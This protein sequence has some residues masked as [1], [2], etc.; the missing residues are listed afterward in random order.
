MAGGVPLVLILL[1]IIVVL[2]L[3]RRRRNRRRAALPVSQFAGGWEQVLDGAV[4]LG[5]GVP[6]KLTRSESAA[7]IDGHFGC[8]ATLLA[9]TA[10]RQV[11]G[12]GDPD[13]VDAERFW[14]EVDSALSG[15]RGTVS[16]WR[17]LR[18]KLSTASLRRGDS[19]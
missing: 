3:K 10:D 18:A 11:F 19:R 5:A 12:P 16:P 9:R 7:V 15:M 4:D 13:P 6:G 8:T 17:R 2:W 1:P 14:A